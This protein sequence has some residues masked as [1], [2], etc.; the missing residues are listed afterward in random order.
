MSAKNLPMEAVSPPPNFMM[1]GQTTMRHGAD[2]GAVYSHR[3][4]NLQS[5]IF[6]SDSPK[7]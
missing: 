1:L 6:S 7:S 2:D 5:C 3:Q 4:D